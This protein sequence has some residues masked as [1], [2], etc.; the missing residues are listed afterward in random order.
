MSH[1][2]KISMYQSTYERV[3]KIAS[4]IGMPTATVIS[5]MITDI[6]LRDMEIKPDDTTKLTDKRKN[7][8]DVNVTISD[9]VYDNIIDSIEKIPHYHIRDYV[10][11]CINEQLK[12]FDNIENAKLST[13]QIQRKRINKSKKIHENEERYSEEV[14]K[15][16]KNRSPLDEYFKDFENMSDIKSGYV[17]KYFLAK[18]INQMLDEYTGDFS[19]FIVPNDD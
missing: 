7:K 18:Q 5:M 15:K 2:I 6:D 16:Y 11:D 1:R 12:Y 3:E 4:N 13:N 19:E 8:K 14:R 9:K 17:K 10:V